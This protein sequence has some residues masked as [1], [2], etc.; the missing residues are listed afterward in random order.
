VERAES[1]RP[2]LAVTGR[3]NELAVEAGVV[4]WHLSLT[5]SDMMA[6]AYVIA[7]G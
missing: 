1:G 6:A 7:A 3:A 5:H 2:S 4:T